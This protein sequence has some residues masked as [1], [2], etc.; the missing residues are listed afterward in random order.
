MKQEDNKEFNAAYDLIHHNSIL[1]NSS[2]YLGQSKNKR[3][4]YL[5]QWLFVDTL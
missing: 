2:F 1:P 5:R 4:F 3:N